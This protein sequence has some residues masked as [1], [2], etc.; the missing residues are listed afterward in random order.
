MN[1]SRLK[2]I[3]V[4]VSGLW[5][6]CTVAAEKLPPRIH[7]FDYSGN[8]KPVHPVL[9]HKLQAML[10]IKN[11]EQ[12]VAEVMQLSEAELIALLPKQGGVYKAECPDVTCGN[13]GE[14][15]SWSISKPDVL[16]CL[17]CKKEL[18]TREYPETHSV[19]VSTP[20]G[21]RVTFRSHIRKDGRHCWISSG[22]DFCKYYRFTAEA[23]R[24]AAMYQKTGDKIYARRSAIII[25]HLAR[26]FAHTPYGRL[27][28]LGSPHDNVYFYDGMPPDEDRANFEISRPARWA[29]YDI[30]AD[31][32]TAYDFIA[33][34]GELQRYAAEINM[35]V[36]REVIRGFFMNTVEACAQKYENY[37][38][39]SPEYWCRMALTGRVLGIPEYVHL[40]VARCRE[41]LDFG[42]Y[43]DGAW[44]EVTGSYHQQSINYIGEVSKVLQ[45]YS[46]PKGFRSRFDGENFRNID[47]LSDNQTASLAR[48]LVRDYMLYP[49]NKIVTINDTWGGRQ[50][51]DGKVT[52][53]NYI[54]SWHH[55][56]LKSQVQDNQ[57]QLRITAAPYSSHRHNDYFNITL[58]ANGLELLGDVGYTHTVYRPYAST[59][60]YH[61]TVV[62][63]H[64]PHQIYVGK[65]KWIDGR[66]NRHISGAMPLAMDIARTDF[67]FVQYA[68]SHIFRKVKNAR[69]TVALVEID[70]NNS[71]AVDFFDFEGSGR[72]YDY[73]LHGNPDLDCVEPQEKEVE[74]YPLVP[75]KV[76]QRLKVPKK[77]SEFFRSRG[78]GYM[79]LRNVR[80]VPGA[81][82]LFKSRWLYDDPAAGL[83]IYMTSSGGKQ[84]FL[85]GSS[86]S[87][88]RAGSDSRLV[89]KFRRPFCMQRVIPN[90]KI[91]R[92]GAIFEP[93]KNKVGLLKKVTPA[94][95]GVW[96]IELDD[97]TDYIFCD[98]KSGVTVDN[99]FMQ[100]NMGFISVDKSG[101]M[102]NHYLMAGV[103]KYG[104]VELTAPAMAELKITGITGERTLIVA[105][106]DKLP[107]NFNPTVV[108]E[109]PDEEGAWF[110]NIQKVD[111]QKNELTLDRPHGVRMLQNGKFERTGFQRCTFDGTGWVKF[112]AP[113]RKK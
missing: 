45:G 102:L 93:L 99:I 59:P 12:R 112:F 5:C 106:L 71:Y 35:D 101:A 40:A 75:R 78:F 61:N 94:A 56:A 58:W 100:G 38:N 113:C 26:M 15:F 32:I 2:W 28:W 14:L 22:I 43:F 86:L 18:T 111:R 39:M 29:Y 88:R 90:S 57:T 68:S 9:R 74:S 110:F 44:W 47:L 34:S 23:L 60:V 55:A 52:P 83:N 53:S 82:S 84:S 73:F 27:P 7:S 79:G 33:A 63:D 98:Q 64:T 105:N 10:K 54:S 62:V 109:F 48:D 16:K 30:P 104:N 31:L 6:L 66:L 65:Q 21:N 89:E 77:E 20:E 103:I 17:I 51:R 11:L 69:R 91:V 81:P 13:R 67:Q 8:Y 50:R 96:K 37:S 42:F 108:V 92:F 95:P 72:T 41:F 107:A 36:E 4:I 19:T 80:K 76:A 87:L 97:R 85:T 25:A 24:L 49:D 1:L 3:A 46:D 70:K